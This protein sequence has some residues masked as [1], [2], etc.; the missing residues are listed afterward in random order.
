MPPIPPRP[1]AA[2]E[3]CAATPQGAA[4]W[5]YFAAIMLPPLLAAAY[6]FHRFAFFYTHY[7]PVAATYRS[8]W[9]WV[10]TLALALGALAACLQARWRR[11]SCLTL[12]HHGL[13]LRIAPR[14]PLTLLWEDI[15]GISLHLTR[16]GL[17]SPRWQGHLTLHLHDGTTV[18]LDSRFPDLPSLAEAFQRR[19]YAA[20]RAE[21][22]QAW[23]HGAPLAFGDV[24]ITPQGLQLRRRLHPWHS[25]R[26]VTIARGQL[27]I[28]LTSG[29][30]LR[31]PL[32]R[33]HNPHVLLW[34]LYEETKR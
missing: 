14:E 9:A 7:G 10:L 27:M 21:L 28:E 1:P 24:A 16:G 17:L 6:A 3:I 18:R 34:W 29:K 15:S 22:R 33:V 32:S 12:K 2:R 8:R 13:T 20:H 31:L 30:A 11:Q 5:G 25:V 23:Q 4:R 19:W 26:Q